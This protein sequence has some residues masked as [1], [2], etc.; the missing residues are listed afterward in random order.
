MSSTLSEGAA[1]DVAALDVAALDV[2]ASDF[3]RSWGDLFPSGT[4]GAYDV[5]EGNKSP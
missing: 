5:P 2:A 3:I 1:S 4:L